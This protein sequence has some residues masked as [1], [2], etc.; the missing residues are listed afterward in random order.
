MVWNQLRYK[1]H[2]PITGLTNDSRKSKKE[3]LYCFKWAKFDGHD[4]KQSQ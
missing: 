3:T 1:I 2:H 4:F